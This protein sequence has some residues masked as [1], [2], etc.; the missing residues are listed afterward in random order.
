M[1]KSNILNI[2]FGQWL[3]F[4]VVNTLTLSTFTY[5]KKYVTVQVAVLFQPWIHHSQKIKLQKER[6]EKRREQKERRN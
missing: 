3:V 1:V 2:F 6:K 5:F 4:V